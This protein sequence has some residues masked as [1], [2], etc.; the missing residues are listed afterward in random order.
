ME[1]KKQDTGLT[2]RR[3]FCFLLAWLLSLGAMILGLTLGKAQKGQ[4][5]ADSLLVPGILTVCAVALYLFG[6]IRKKRFVEK[7]NQ[8]PVGEMMDYFAKHRS[9]AQADAEAKGRS[10]KRIRVCFAVCFV[11]LAVLLLAIPFSAGFFGVGSIVV[12][13]FVLFASA[14]LT[15]LIEW[16][17]PTEK[18]TLTGEEFLLT[19][20]EFPALYGVFARA[21]KELGLKKTPYVA[22]V[23][24][25]DCSVWQKRKG[26]ILTVGAEALAIFSEE[27]LHCVALHELSHVASAEKRHAQIAFSLKAN[28]A[29]EAGLFCPYWL[30][31]LIVKHQW[32]ETVKRY[33]V[34]VLDELD[35][36]RAMREHGS[37]EAAASVLLK[38]QYHDYYEW[39]GEW[40]KG[41][42]FAPEECIGNVVE[43]ETKAFLKAVSERHA[44]WDTLYPKEILSGK[45][46]HPT[47]RMRLEQL[48]IEKAELLQAED[49]EAYRSEIAAVCGK[50]GEDFKKEIDENYA[51]YRQNNYV[52]PS[53]RIAAWEAEGSP[54]KAETYVDLLGD[55]FRLCRVPD[56]EALC[57]RVIAEL[58]EGAIHTACLDKASILLRRFDPEGIGY[59]YRAVENDNLIDD[60]LDL[61]GRFCCMTGNEEE[62]GK[63][64]ETAAKLLQKEKEAGGQFGFFA[65]GDDLKAEELPDGMKENILEYIH[66][67]DRGIV[68]TVLLVRKTLKNGEFCS[69]FVLE[70]TN[71]SKED[72]RDEVYHAV[73]RFLD[74]Y[75]VDWSFA[76]LDYD[77]TIAA[78]P[79]KIEGAVVWKK[80]E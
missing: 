79:E 75:P 14:S 47:L 70:Y 4:W 37:A 5:S 55:L 61:I 11:L 77:N 76:L 44:L 15:T 42:V 23:G 30:M 54:V 48:G 41:P 1:Q 22:A 43:F 65:K 28:R 62:L 10:M 27:E 73:F 33:A 46:T 68:K 16:L 59:A 60:G 25:I 69:T 57:D 38:L 26:A 63:Y 24:G 9:D 6:R 35:A 80:E 7:I 45:A 58:P 56:A 74:S 32:E 40:E 50:I 19:E 29:S 71:D 2:I 21:A 34:S 52:K 31:P 12:I 72:D 36:D 66:S 17:V 49:S 18:L 8:T 51:E 39:E 78:H 13:L 53:E 3:T 67:V 20:K 64:R